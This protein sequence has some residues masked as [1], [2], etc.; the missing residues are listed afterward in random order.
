MPNAK[1]QKFTG[2]DWFLLFFSDR[3]EGG[4]QSLG[5]NFPT[6]FFMPT[7]DICMEIIETTNLFIREQISDETRRVFKKTIITQA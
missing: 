3:G 6:P 1:I 4:G 2:N 7:T 5:E